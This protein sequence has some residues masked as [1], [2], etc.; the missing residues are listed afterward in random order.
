MINMNFHS[1]SVA[2]TTVGYMC[3]ALT[4][5]MLSMPNASWFPKLYGHGAAMT[6]PLA[7]VLAIMGILSFTQN[8][9]LDAII[10]FGGAGLFWSDYTYY[11]ALNPANSM[12]PPSYTGWYVFIWAV[13]F[14]YVWFGSFK[15][16][17][18][19]MLFLLGLWLTL[20]ALAIGNWSSVH[21]LIVLG[22]YLGLITSILAAITSATD[23]IKHGIKSANP[24]FEL[25]QT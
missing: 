16:G 24:N 7:I 13:F 8:R 14:C 17:I 23:V 4:G 9:A 25:V 19:R 5:W 21:G 12:D 11:S 15:S 2:T 18:P 22:G 10:F 1:K 3:L 20:L 6:Y